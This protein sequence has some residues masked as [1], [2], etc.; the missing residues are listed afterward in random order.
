MPRRMQVGAAVS[1]FVWLGLLHTG[2]NIHGGNPTIFGQPPQPQPVAGIILIVAAF[3]LPP[4][5]YGLFK[6]P[7]PPEFFE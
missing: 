6:P 4:L 5:I 2:L 7:L 1:F 3:V